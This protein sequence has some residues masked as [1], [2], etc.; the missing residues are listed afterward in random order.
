MDE[1][2]TPEE[3]ALLLR[4]QLSWVYEKSRSR[5]RDPLPCHRIGRYIRFKKSEVMQWFDRT[6]MP[7]KKGRR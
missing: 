2:I 1:I 3:C 6:A 7:A 4:V 5:S